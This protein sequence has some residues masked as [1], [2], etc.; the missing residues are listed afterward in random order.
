VPLVGIVD[1]APHL[2]Q[3][4]AKKTHFE[5]IVKSPQF[6]AFYMKWTLQRTTMTADFVSEVEITLFSHTC[7][8]KMV[9]RM[10]AYAQR[11]GQLA[12]QPNIGGTSAKVR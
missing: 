11:D 7:N 1:S 9:T 2:G 6:Q 12:T 8:D 5:G 4:P 3:I 10:Q